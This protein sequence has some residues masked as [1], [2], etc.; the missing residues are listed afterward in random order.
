MG[1]HGGS[2]LSQL[3]SAI[4]SAGL[5][6]TSNPK[7]K[8]RKRDHSRDSLD[9]E[10]KAARLQE[11][12]K[13]LNPFDL[14]VTKPKHDIPGQRV[15]GVTGRPSASH[16]AGLELRKNTLL[17][18]YRKKNRIGGLIDRRFGEQDPN[19]T[20]EERMLGR[21]TRERQRNAK[22][23]FN[24]EDE[25]ELTHYG[26][27]L[28]ADDFERTGIALSDDED[29][30][31][32]EA[33]SKNH[34]GGFEEDQSDDQDAPTRKKSKNE[35]MN[36]VME[37][38]KQHKHERQAQKEADDDLRHQLDGEFADFRQ[39][40]FSMPNQPNSAVEPEKPTKA[41]P[42]P[43]ASTLKEAPQLDARDD[44]DY[45]RLVREFVFDKRAK[46]TDRLK[47]EEEIAL[48]EKQKLEKA[49]RARIR[50]MNGEEDYDS[51]DEDDG[52]NRRKSA[53]VPQADDLEDDFE[54]DD[55]RFLSSGLGS[56][57]P[58]EEDVTADESSGSNDGDESAESD[59]EED[60]LQG[61]LPESDTD[62][63]MS[64]NDEDLIKAARRSEKGKA[65]VKEL[66]FT[67]ECPGTH[68]EFLD[69]I[70][71]IDE[72]DIPTV[73]QRIR[74]LYHPSLAEGNK[75]R[76]E[77]LTD[78]LV[79]HI[80]YTSSSSSNPFP[81]V[82]ALFP[83]ILSLTKAYTITSARAFVSKLTIMQKNL[84]RG[85]AQGPTFLDAKTFPGVAELVLLRVIGAIWSTSDLW[86]P[87]VTPAVILIGQYLGQSRIRNIADLASG[88]FL[89]TLHLQARI[90]FPILRTSYN[91]IIIQYQTLSHRLMPETLNF[92][93]NACLLLSPHSLKKSTLPGNF[94]APDFTKD[95][96]KP[97]K[98]NSRKASSPEPRTP[99]LLALL[100]PI[101]PQEQHKADLLNTV[102]TLLSKFAELHKGLEGFV[103]L[104]QPV[105]DVLSALETACYS[106]PL[107]VGLL[108]FPVFPLTNNSRNKKTH[109]TALDAISRMLKFARQ[110]RQPLHLQAHKP[111]PIRSIAPM[112]DPNF[113]GRKHTSKDDS[114]AGKLKAMYKKEKK[115]A[116]KELRKDNKFLAIE[117]AKQQAEKDREYDAKMKRA[118]G[119]ISNERAEE[120]KMARLKETEKKRAGKR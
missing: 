102:F 96:L 59:S 17:V 87:V 70:S 72:K 54:L 95:T 89:C 11:I 79:D 40:L 51:S 14:K 43:E 55:E 117:K 4:N 12:T 42:N 97:L 73:V 1:K 98:L 30:L 66:P 109:W 118:V 80:L 61:D 111:I 112:F 65:A 18:E 15:K 84:S 27:S 110:G 32:R 62:T 38:S 6:R 2:Q 88:L 74:A 28:N 5:S 119:E 37:K 21:F 63:S 86:H 49:E 114:E 77:T 34:F 57:V 106:P 71:G 26:K 35:V 116:V 23:S 91:I 45:D 68:D 10:K 64:G 108:T 105:V 94:P 82:T 93:L 31:D 7:S 104:F 81:L 41:N 53:R 47:T 107:K 76:L 29:A 48:E 8:K 85:L 16:Q 50:R 58:S 75:A 67:F 69:I 60:D 83:H 44:D 99:D 25:D 24:L 33:V 46:P 92:L 20:Q 3:Q 115:A 113:S 22:Y 52:R 101:E 19:M 103:E 39:L 13:K 100:Q 120:K 78:I 9:P 56:D 36:E 90:H